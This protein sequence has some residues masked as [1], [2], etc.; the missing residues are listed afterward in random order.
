MLALVSGHQATRR[1]NDPPPRE[2]VATAGQDVTDGARRPRPTRFG[3]HLAVRDEVTR[4]Q[5]S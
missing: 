3:R 2:V 1:R 5:C 4:L